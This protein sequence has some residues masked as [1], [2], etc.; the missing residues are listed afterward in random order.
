MRKKLA[1][2]SA[3]LA[4]AVSVWADESLLSGLKIEPRANIRLQS[5]NPSI[6]YDE[7][8]DVYENRGQRTAVGTLFDITFTKEYESG[9]VVLL[10]IQGNGNTQEGGKSNGVQI[11]AWSDLNS[12]F[13]SADDGVNISD[14]NI[15]QPFFDNKVSVIF[16]K[17]GTDTYLS[18]NE[19]GEFF[20]TNLFN[21]DPIFIGVGGDLYGLA[22]KIS[23][24]E[25]IDIFASYQTN[26]IDNIGWDYAAAE[27]TFKLPIEGNEGNYRI[28]YWQ[29]NE[30]GQIKIDSGKNAAA[31]GLMISIDQKIIDG[32]LLFGRYGAPITQT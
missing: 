32:V 8:N 15:S 2:L 1:V 20:E 14:L 9:A 26:D 30:S 3:V 18:S 21:P 7:D 16:G 27:L 19:A 10:N 4:F 29:N 6:V 31:S 11:S 12:G 17:F 13:W 25:Y 22:V 24:I 23:P 28:G 5:G